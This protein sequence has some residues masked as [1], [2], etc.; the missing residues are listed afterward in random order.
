[1]TMKVNLNC[2]FL[3]FKAILSDAFKA[4]LLMTS[5][6]I[7]LEKRTS[8]RNSIE[9]YVC[10]DAHIGIIVKAIR[11]VE[12]WTFVG[13]NHKVFCNTSD[14]HICVLFGVDCT[15]KRLHD[16]F[17]LLLC[18][19]NLGMQTEHIEYA[20]LDR[21]NRYVLC[22]TCVIITSQ[23]GRTFGKTQIDGIR[24]RIKKDIFGSCEF[25]IVLQ[26]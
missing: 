25:D 4:N 9:L 20:D 3:S 8:S 6:E 19:V 13:S 7:T 23:R 2:N 17:F 26:N 24:F 1:M 16:C 12:R 15:M 10:L 18:N 11:L 22:R 5:L 21:R 14:V